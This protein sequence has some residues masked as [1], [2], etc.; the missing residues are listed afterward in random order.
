[1]SHLCRNV[2]GS[3]LVVFTNT[4]RLGKEIVDFAPIVQDGKLFHAYGGSC[5]SQTD[6]TGDYL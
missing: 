2:P 4:L 5:P 6:L 3:C 1:M